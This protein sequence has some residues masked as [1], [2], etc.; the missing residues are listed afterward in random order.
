MS[1][2]TEIIL[3]VED[4]PDDLFLLTRAFEKA[5]LGPRLRIVRDGVEATEYLVGKGLYSDRGRFPTPGLIV[6]DLKMPRLSGIEF[7]AWRHE[8]GE[9]AK[10]PVVILTAS[11]AAADVRRA[12]QGG[13][14]SYHVKP[15]AFADLVALVREMRKVM[16]ASATGVDAFAAPLPRATLPSPD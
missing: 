16:D 6:L 14:F 7:L 2:S 10:I 15:A 11:S 12:Y 3:A 13:A 5:E 8:R 9:F 1:S 4:N